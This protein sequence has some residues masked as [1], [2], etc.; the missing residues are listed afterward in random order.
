MLVVSFNLNI[1]VLQ[2]RKTF[3]YFS[4]LLVIGFLA[5]SC[6]TKKNTWSR[7]AYHNTTAHFNV[8]FN[9]NEALKEGLKMVAGYHEDDY[10]E[11]LNV[12]QLSTKEKVSGAS[13]QLERSITKAGMVIHSHSMFFDNQEK[14]K[15]VYMSYLMMGKAQFYKQDYSNAKIT[16]LYITTKYPKESIKSDA[17]LWLARIQVLEGN[18]SEAISNLDML[19]N[20]ASQGA[21]SKE[22]LRMLPLVYADIYLKQ[23][24]YSPAIQYLKDAIELNPGKKV[25]C[26]QTFILAQVY[27][28]LGQNKNAI[29]QYKKVLKLS[30]IYLMDFNAR[31]NM[32]KCYRGGSD[33]KSIKA[34]VLKM[35]KDE[36]NKDYL[37][38]IYYVLAEMEL[39]E[40]NQEKAIEYLQLS[41]AKSVSNNKQK[42]F[43]ALKLGQ[44]YFD[45][46]NYTS[47]QAYYDSTMAFLPKDYVGYKELEER[48]QILTELVGYLLTVQKE[49]SLQKISS[50]SENER[51]KFIDKLIEEEVKA[52]KKRIEEEQLIQ[53]NMSMALEN[54]NTIKSVT[55][56]D[57]AKWYFY[58]Q[59]TMN[60]GLKEFKGKWG[61]R[62]LE[63]FWRLSNKDFATSNTE[64]NPNGENKTEEDG[65]SDPNNPKS[66]SKKKEITDKK[67][68]EFYLKDLPK[69]QKDIDTSNRKIEMALY[70]QG[71]VYKE[72][73][74]NQKKAYKA[75][76]ELLRRFP[77]TSYAAQTYYNLYQIYSTLEMP[78]EAEKYKTM[79]LNDFPESDFAK[80]L[81]DPDYHKK[82]SSQK[83]E[84]KN[85][86]KNA[87]NFYKNG[88]YTS[89]LSIC[90]TAATRLISDKEMM[91]KFDLLKCLCYGKTTSTAS[92]ISYLEKHI[93][94]FPTASTKEFAQNLLSAL[95]NPEDQLKLKNNAL[96]SLAKTRTTANNTSRNNAVQNVENA[97]KSDSSANQIFNL[98]T[99]TKHLFIILISGDD[100]QIADLKNLI[101]N[102][103]QTYFGSDNLKINSGLLNQQTMIV[104]VSIFSNQQ[105]ALDY[106]SASRRNID[107]YT[108][109]RNY[110]GSFYVISNENYIKLLQTKDIQSFKDF[111]KKN[112]N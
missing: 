5:D 78:T 3:I 30:P 79:L 64:D 38:Q 106:Q 4:I 81:S 69:N 100:P 22:V 71:V 94:T 67:S 97:S 102:H 77:K 96:D 7:R 11:V 85:Q 61:Q 75:F 41:V 88:D 57:N 39:V 91:A 112:F 31:I 93:S 1:L 43:S 59:T 46:Q 32:A 60:F 95:K 63:D 50:M 66:G 47:A 55:G 54:N 8:Y 58:N 56:N 20:K 101:S 40:K 87:Y 110:E 84:V 21:V 45:R 83:D 33:G 13:S 104:N 92:F 37:D 49:D 99:E 53:L 10:S 15:W 35:L 36:K 109:L 98:N 28:Q 108:V 23:K 24:N 51:N 90:T 86:Y 82:L 27:Q 48:N 44:I 26:R 2:I 16:F 80:I 73:L 9:G 52:E 12:F 29:A 72:K 74:K 6:S 76:E 18:Y 34:S 89:A 19:K 68:R 17:L 70:G 105:S 111:Y 65:D 25:R 107:L 14:V 42:A 103:N 62:K